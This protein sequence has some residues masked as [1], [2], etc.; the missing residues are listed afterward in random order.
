MSSRD[1]KAARPRRDLRLSMRSIIFA[2]ERL[3]LGHALFICG[4]QHFMTPMAT[5]EAE[6]SK[7]D[8]NVRTHVPCAAP[9]AQSISRW[10]AESTTSTAPLWSTA[11]PQGHA[12][13]CKLLPSPLP[14][15]TMLPCAAPGAQRMTR[16]LAESVT[17]KAPLWS[18]ATEEGHRNCCKPLPSVG[19]IPFQGR[20]HFYEGD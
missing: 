3:S 19:T 16:L 8:D 10:L 11:M 2:S 13:W 18:T 6:E 4:C 17:S 12:N 20:V 5:A 7:R 1:P 15:A 14:P 9:G